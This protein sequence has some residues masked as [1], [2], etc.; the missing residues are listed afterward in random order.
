MRVLAGS[1]QRREGH[2][3]YQSSGARNLLCKAACRKRFLAALGMTRVAQ[4]DEVS[5]SA[6]GRKPGCA[7]QPV[8]LLPASP[9]AWL[10]VLQAA[11]ALGPVVLA[12]KPGSG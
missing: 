10:F 11:P 5:G 7:S 9:E 2:P 1:P 6:T 3:S 12:P 8:E 4:A